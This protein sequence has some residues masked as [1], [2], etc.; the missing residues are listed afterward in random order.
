MGGWSDHEQRWVTAMR[1]ANRGCAR[2]YEQLLRE[3][4]ANLRAMAARDLARLG[5]GTSDIDDVVQECLLA[6]HLKRHT[7]DESRPI[8]PWVRA[9]ARHKIIDGARQRSRAREVPLGGQADATPDPAKPLAVQATAI[10]RCLDDLPPRQRDVVA[11][12]AL[13]GESVG[14]TA[15]KLKI[16]AGAVRVALHRG[17]AALALKFG[18]WL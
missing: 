14:G 5:F 10:E 18:N 1:A 17:L 7:W 13:E 2:S 9:I 11:M 8:V 12:L 3:L 4:A 6:I 16:S 15:R